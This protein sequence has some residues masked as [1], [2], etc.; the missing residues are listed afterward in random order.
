MT[1]PALLADTNVMT[2]S[3]PTRATLS[4]LPVEMLDRIFRLVDNSDLI[5]L[6]CVS[7]YISTIASRPFAIRNF[8]NMRHVVTEESMKT[9]LAISAHETFGAHIKSIILSP[10]RAISAVLEPL[11]FSNIEDDGIV[12]DNSFIKSGRFS[13]LM[14]QVLSNFKQHSDSIAIGVKEDCCLRHSRRDQYSVAPKQQIFHGERAFCKAAELGTVFETSETLELLFAEMR[15]AAININRL[16]IELARDSCYNVRGKT[17]RTIKKLLESRNSSI[18]LKIRWK[19]HGVLKY[20]HLQSSLR[21]SASSLLLDRFDYRADVLLLDDIVQQ[22]TDRSVWELYLRELDNG[23]LSF[24]NMYF[25]QSLRT[26]TLADINLSSAYFAEDL[27]SNMFERLSRIPDLR[28]CKL[29][30]L[31]Y[32][33]QQDTSWSPHMMQT[34][35]GRYPSE[36]ETL[37][38]VFP[39]GKFEFEIQ[40]ADISQQLKDLAAYTAAA[41][42]EK[43]R[44]TEAARQ[45]IDSRVVGAGV[46]ILEQEDPEYSSL[47]LVTS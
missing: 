24:L 7:R 29:H 3:S 17:Q 35:S 31:H 46:P 16:E 21:F 23:R 12:V 20:K 11:D 10:V 1:D 43:V 15:A 2:S 6:R 19:Y 32:L 37:L 27:Y 40:G 4:T 13:D 26:V 36:R 5:H 33:L 41:E 45:V 44:E 25:I 8:G 18:D 22:L 42:K 39:D 34:R 14:Q 38:L 28:H 30:R 47:A 9:L